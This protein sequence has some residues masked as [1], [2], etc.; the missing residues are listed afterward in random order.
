MGSQKVKIISHP[1]GD[2]KKCKDC[3]ECC[4]GAHIEGEAALA[5]AQVPGYSETKDWR[6]GQHDDFWNCGH[7]GAGETGEEAEQ[8]GAGSE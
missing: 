5:G 3:I 2:C 6:A 7:G 4:Q 8:K 1:G